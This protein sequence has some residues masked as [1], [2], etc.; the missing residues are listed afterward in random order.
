MQLPVLVGCVSVALLVVFFIIFI[1]I[2][3][4]K[5]LAKL[6]AVV[7]ESYETLEVFL[8]KRLEIVLKIASMLEEIDIKEP[9]IA[10]VLNVLTLLKGN[11]ETSK[12]YSLEAN[13]TF[14]L[15]TAMDTL[16]NIHLDETDFIQLVLNCSYVQE[17]IKRTR[18]YYNNNVE[19]YNKLLNKF[20]SSIIARMFK[21]KKEFYV[22]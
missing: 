11:K 16:K 1:L 14:A 18:N 6:K 22:R 21:F 5:K 4:Y 13:L 17:D 20:P 7:K 9:N 15:D 10:T 8:D 2:R 12:R 3:N 19:A